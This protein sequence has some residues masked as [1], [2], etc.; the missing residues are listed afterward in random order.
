MMRLLPLLCLLLIAC[1]GDP[2]GT[3]LDDDDAVHVLDD[4]DDGAPLEHVPDAWQPPEYDPYA[5]PSDVPTLNI[6][7]DAAAMQRLDEDPFAAPDER[8]VFVDEHGVAHEVDL[9]YRGAYALLNVM[10]GYGLRNWKVKFDADDPY[11]G[12]REWNL[13]YEPH[14]IQKLAMD[15]MRFAGVPVPGS[16][17]VILELN[18]E[19]QGIYLRYEDPDDKRWLW[20]QFGHDDGDLYKAAFDIPY[21]PQ[22]FADLTVLGDADEDYF[23]HYSKKTNNTVAPDD[24]AVLRTFIAELDEL[25]EDELATWFAARFDLETFR[26][27]L[28]VSNFI[29]NWDAYPQ[30]P[31]NFWLYEDLRADR[32][33][34]VPWDLDLAFNPYADST[35][36]QMGT[37]AS[38]LFNLAHADYYPPP[39][40]DEGTE[41]PLVRRMIVLD[42]QQDAYLER[43]RELSATILTA[44]YLEDRLSA[45]T[46][47]VLPHVSATDRERI[48]ANEGSLRLFIQ[49]RTA[50][51]EAELDALR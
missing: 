38:V 29:A 3:T 46:D 10:N 7:L 44:Q 14:F 21:E 28:V 40:E 37:S 32:M 51:V 25:P 33:A 43:Y 4:D 15:L 49:Q 27:Y 8:G 19:Y 20:D 18:G 34:F 16:Q 12:R 47:L 11:L 1:G 41:R 50:A 17:H 26:S 9:N 42:G 2:S 5:L 45:L 30:R 35:Y 13:N 31:K 36:N 24:Y 23:C 39:H 22:C 6:E 48:E